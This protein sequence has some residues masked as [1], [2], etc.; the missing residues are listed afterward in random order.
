MDFETLAIHAGQ[1]PDDKNGAVMVP[2]FQTSTYVQDGVGKP[3]AGYEYSRT[4]N[5]T[6]L[7]LNRS[8]S[9]WRMR[10]R[11]GVRSGDGCHGRCPAAAGW[12]RMPQGTMST[13]TFRLFDKVLPPRPGLRLR[14]DRSESWRSAN[15]RY[16][17]R[18]VGS[19]INPLLA[20]TTT[21]VA[22]I[23]HAAKAASGG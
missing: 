10:L 9:A 1:A 22:E 18:L 6:R 5:P 4:K 8:G 23:V 12:W 11:A 21:A 17:A 7:A 19:R 13:G 3:R 15:G 14:D 16:P 20:I 2:I